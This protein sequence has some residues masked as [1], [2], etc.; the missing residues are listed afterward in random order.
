MEQRIVL[1]GGQR[2]RAGGW[3]PVLYG[4][5]RQDQRTAVQKDRMG[6]ITIVVDNLPW[7]MNQK[8]LFLLFSKFGVFK[9]VFIPNKTRKS[10]RSRFGFVIYDCSVVAEVVIQKA[11]GIWC[12]DKELH[13]KKAAFEKVRSNTNIG[14]RQKRWLLIDKPGGYMGRYDGRVDNEMMGHQSYAEALVHG[15]KHGDKGHVILGVELGNRW[16]YDSVVVKLK[17]YYAFSDFH[18]SVL[19]IGFVIVKLNE[20]EQGGC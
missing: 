4:K 17:S 14:G 15:N 18:D 6:V 2:I 19:Q 1:G 7:S 3:Q 20:L 9:D 13:V 11:N 8:G 5:R 16:L 10:T 12:D